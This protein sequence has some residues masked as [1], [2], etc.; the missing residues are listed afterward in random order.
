MVV[1]TGTSRP[2]PRNTRA[3]P[4]ASRSITG[5]SGSGTA[6][7][8]RS[9]ELFDPGRA[10]ALLV[11]AVLEDGAERDLDRVLVDGA[12]PERGERVRPVDGLGD[13]RWFV[14]LEVAHRL[15]RGRDL[16]REL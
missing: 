5:S 12:A 13:S 15:H 16:A 1:P 9:H 4:T 11:L 8:G 7:R 6:L 3:N 14:E 2:A 10:R